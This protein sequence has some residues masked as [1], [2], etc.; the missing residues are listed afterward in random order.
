M[1][2][3]HGKLEG[4]QKVDQQRKEEGHPHENPQVQRLPFQFP[5]QMSCTD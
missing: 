4:R 1:E 3:V 5:Q 2:T